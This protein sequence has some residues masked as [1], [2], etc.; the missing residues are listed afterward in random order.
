MKTR[1]FA[2]AVSVAVIAACGTTDPDGS[3]EK[4]TIRIAFSKDYALLTKS[5]I[6]SMPDTNDF[7]LKISDAAGRSIYNG[8]FGAAPETVITDPGS[9]TVDVMSSE[10]KTPEFDSPQYGDS[11]VISVLAGKTTSVTM[12][13]TQLNAGIRLKISPDFLTVY[14]SGVLYLKSSDGRLMY[15][16]SEKRIAF[17]KPGPITLILNDAGIENQLFT[18]NLQAREIMTI[19]IDT[20]TATSTK[21]GVHVQVDTSR[22]WT[23]ANFKIGQGGDGDDTDNAFSI[24]QAKSH[25]GESDKWVYGYIVGGDLSSSRCSFDLPFTARTNIAIAAKSSCRDKE[26]CLS[27]KLSQG[28]IRDALN[29]VDHPENLGR[30]IFIKGDIVSSYYGIPGIQG[31]SEYKWK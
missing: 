1:L 20:G 21:G 16:Y 22:N 9:Y 31:I 8:K 4:G 17:F 18:R 6:K 15:S 10:F 2:T 24:S 27:V 28:D 5:D 19:A 13:C 12:D 23:S 7:I 3:R 26:Q 14:P 25:I 29:L 30:Q 11:R